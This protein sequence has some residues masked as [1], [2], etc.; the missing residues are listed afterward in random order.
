MDASFLKALKLYRS[1][2]IDSLTKGRGGLA[3]V[4]AP[5]FLVAQ[6]RHLHLNVDAVEQRAG[7]SGAVAL[8]LQWRAAAFFLGIGEESTLTRVHGCHQHEARPLIDRYDG[9]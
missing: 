7:D 9:P 1:S 6:C 3:G 2:P 8:N 5:Q 4:S